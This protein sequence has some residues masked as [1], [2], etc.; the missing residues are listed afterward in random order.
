MTYK[1]IISG[2]LEFGN[3]RSCE[4]AMQLFQNRYDIIYRTDVFLKLEEV[5]QLEHSYLDL[6]RFSAQVTEKTWNNTINLLDEVTQFAIAG[7]LEAW[8]TDTGQV[9]QYRVIEP[10]TEKTAVRAFLRGRKL[11]NDGGHEMEAIGSLS[12]AIEKY[13]RHAL[14]YERRGFVN[15]RLRN[16][17]D[18]LYDYNKSININPAGAE[19]YLGRAVVHIAQN[20]HAA[21]LPDLEKAI[22]FSVPLQPVYWIARR[23][24][25]DCHL[26]LKQHEAAVAEYQLFLKRA[27]KP[28]DVNFLR[29]RRAGFRLGKALLALRKSKEALQAFEYALKIESDDPAAPDAEVKSWHAEALQRSNTRAAAVA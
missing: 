13:E 9:L 1:V 6:Y 12:E 16:Y 11:I 5:F 2:R 27:F 28:G 17:S 8:L 25:G 26:E 23:I 24:K 18:A 10:H 21:A 7:K 19:A 22:K 20:D 29:R 14:A 15:Y 3:A 4:K